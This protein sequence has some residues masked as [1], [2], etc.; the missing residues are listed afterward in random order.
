MGKEGIVTSV[1]DVCSTQ[2][3]RTA[4]IYYDDYRLTI[5]F[6]FNITD[7]EN[8]NPSYFKTDPVECSGKMWAATGGGNFITDLM[9][10]KTDK[11]TQDWY[12]DFDKTISTLNFK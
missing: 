8:N 10:G 11:K 7:L 6:N 4:Y 5:G 1:I 9:A 12:K 3:N 2:L